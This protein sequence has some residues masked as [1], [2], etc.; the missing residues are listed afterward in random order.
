MEEK[1]AHSK[2]EETIFK[3]DMFCWTLNWQTMGILLDFIVSK[4]ILVYQPCPKGKQGLYV[5]GVQ[6]YS[7]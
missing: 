2:L 7:T 1:W 6:Y 3:K 4:T 5:E